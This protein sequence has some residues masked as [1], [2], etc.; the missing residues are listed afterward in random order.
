MN[1]NL[2]AFSSNVFDCKTDKLRNIEPDDYIMTN[3]GYN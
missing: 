1:G 3:A 2:F